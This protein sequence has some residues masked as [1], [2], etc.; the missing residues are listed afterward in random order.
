MRSQPSDTFNIEVV[1]WLVKHD[2]VEIL[3]Q[4]G[5]QSHSTTL[6]TTQIFYLATKVKVGQQARNHIAN[7]GIA[8]PLV[9]FKIANHRLANSLAGVNL[10]GLVKHSH[11]QIFAVSDAAAVRLKALCQQFDQR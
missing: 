11:Q 4:Q 5:C 3:H 10:V 9:L 2:D 7:L 8:S 1:S 6:A